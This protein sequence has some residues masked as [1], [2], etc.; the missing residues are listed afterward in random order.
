[1]TPH[2]QL[3][4]VCNKSGLKVTKRSRLQKSC[5]WMCKACKKA[6]VLKKIVLFLEEEEKLSVKE[7]K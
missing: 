7:E 4:A 3:T 5:P 6:Q 2:F 1:M